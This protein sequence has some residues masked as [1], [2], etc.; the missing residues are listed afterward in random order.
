MTTPQ[1]LADNVGILKTRMGAF[2][3]GS[4]A[5]FRGHD[6]HAE[7]R[8]MD[9][10]ELYLFGITGRRFTPQ[11][12]ELLHGILV[13]TSYP[14]A[15]IW[16][17]RVAALAGTA[18]TTPGLGITAAMA[19]SEASIYG[20][21]PGVKSFNFFLRV[22]RHVAAGGDL[23]EFVAKE[24]RIYGFGRPTPETYDERIPW[25]KAL[26]EKL[27]LADGPH[28]RIALAVEKMLTARH[29][30]L[31]MNY[32]AITAS[33]CADMGFSIF[34]FQVFRV[35]LFMAGMPPCYIEAVQKPEGATFPVPCSGVR[36]EGAARRRWKPAE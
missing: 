34:E 21:Q 22:Q 17:N 2:F 10:V 29:G 33:L 15:R 36:Y 14:D 25:L 6:L 32:A 12:L 26:A 19:V 30:H 23:A 3:A 1:A 4:R 13:Y 28:F 18:R 11:Q 16:N 20:G 8:D 27:G 9:W 24:G 31:H 35:P 7:L 5:V